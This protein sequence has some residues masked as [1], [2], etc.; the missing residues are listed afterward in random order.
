MGLYGG[1]N[2]LIYLEFRTASL[3]AGAVASRDS[4]TRS[5]GL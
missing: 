2:R 4:R 5:A 1:E 3:E